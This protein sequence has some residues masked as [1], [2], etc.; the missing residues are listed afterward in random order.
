MRLS[1]TSL[2]LEG[3]GVAFGKQVVLAKIDLAVPRRGVFILVGPPGS[4]KSALL[5]TLATLNNSQPALRTWGEAFFS[6][7]RLGEEGCPPASMVHQS[8]RL[9][10]SSLRENLFS[11]IAERSSLRRTEQLEIIRDSLRRLGEEEILQHLDKQAIDLPLGMQRR[12]AIIRA[13]LSRAPLILID[14]PTSGINDEAEASRIVDLIK[15]LAE[16]HAVLVTTHHRG[17]ARELGGELALIAGGAV[18][19][20]ARTVDFLDGPTTQAGKDWLATG[21]CA[22]PS[23]SARP[24]DLAEDA[25]RPVELPTESVQR[26]ANAT[27]PRGFFWLIE[28][29]LAGMPRPGIVAD[30]EDDL[31]GIQSL[32]VD[33]LITLE[34]TRALP[35]D[36]LGARGIRVDHYPIPDMG[37]P[38]TMG[39]ILFCA[40]LDHLLDEGHIIAMHCLAG[41]GRT[42]TML[43]AYAIWRG[44]T[45]LEA[46][47]LVRS[48]RPLAIQSDEQVR[49]L[50]DF[51][52]T[53]QGERPSSPPPRESQSV[54]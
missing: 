24:E 29:Q 41:L 52:R 37:A 36:L 32:G 23:P 19:E 18:Q 34:E 30:L 42:G 51:A 9:L 16:D 53:L 8:A 28:G 6:G 12:I 33:L 14:E 44:A 43:A 40:R 31:D 13:S 27:E 45:V 50:E 35:E 47:E 21:H 22:I 46:F 38:P 10:V 17:H 48:A 3:F 7:V 26:V 11:A 4:G 54:N 20:R 2:T 49:F 15:L 1:E 39:A 25:P 5:R